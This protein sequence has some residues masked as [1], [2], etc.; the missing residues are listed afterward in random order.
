MS[1]PQSADTNNATDNDSD[2]RFNFFDVLDA[3]CSHYG[4]SLHVILHEWTW[5]VFCVRWVRLIE[6][7][8]DQREEQE[9][10]DRERAFA[11]LRARTEQEHSA[12]MRPSY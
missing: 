5:K 8:A 6:Y 3:M 2:G 10:R 1:A 9:K 4:E 11:E 12:Q 7:T